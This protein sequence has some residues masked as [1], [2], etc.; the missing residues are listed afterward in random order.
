MNKTQLQVEAIH[1]GTVIDHIP[2]GQGIRI[3]QLFG[4]VQN[5]ERITVGLNLPSK[6]LGA[7]DIIKVE[8][9]RLSPAQANQLALFAPDATVNLIEDFEVVEKLQLHLPEQVEGVFACP[10]GNCISRREP[11]TSQFRVRAVRGQVMFRCR[12]CEKSFQRDMMVL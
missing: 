11:E 5:R 8:N 2:A 4:L 6:A 9:V 3:L 12:Y 1:N 7:K 10:N